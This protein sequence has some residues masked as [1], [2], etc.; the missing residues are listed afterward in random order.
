MCTL[1]RPSTR[2]DSRDSLTAGASLTPEQRQ[3]AWQSAFLHSLDLHPDEEIAWEAE[4]WREL[5]AH[6]I[7]GLCEALLAERRADDFSIPADVWRSDLDALWRHVPRSPV[8]RL[9]R[10]GGQCLV[11]GLRLTYWMGATAEELVA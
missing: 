11:A 5:G 7:T 10:A 1:P 8:M 3:C 9:V 4:R 6:G 2:T